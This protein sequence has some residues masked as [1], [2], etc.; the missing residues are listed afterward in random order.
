MYEYKSLQFAQ[1]LHLMTKVTKAFFA[2]GKMKVHFSGYNV[3]FRVY[4]MIIGKHILDRDRY[5]PDIQS[6]S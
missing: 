5:C 1:C 6:N 4:I 2:N 3:E